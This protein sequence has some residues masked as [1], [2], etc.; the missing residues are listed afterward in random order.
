RHYPKGLKVSDAELAAV[1]LIGH[2][3]HPDWNYTII[4]RVKE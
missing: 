3:F 1:N 4:P 2:E